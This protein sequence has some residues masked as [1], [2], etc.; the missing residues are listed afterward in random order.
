MGGGPGGPRPPKNIFFPFGR[1]YFQTRPLQISDTRRA[2]LTRIEVPESGQRANIM[3]AKNVEIFSR[4]AK[5]AIFSGPVPHF[6]EKIF[7]NRRHRRIRIGVM[8]RL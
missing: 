3:A 6:S 1:K 2:I 5:G 4:G 8:I 7:L